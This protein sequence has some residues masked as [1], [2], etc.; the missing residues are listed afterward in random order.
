MDPYLKDLHLSV[1][2]GREN[3]NIGGW[4]VKEPSIFLGRRAHDE[5]WEGDGAMIPPPAEEGEPEWVSPK[6]RLGRDIRCLLE[7]TSTEAPT[8]IN[9]RVTA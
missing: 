7:L 2:G 5:V 1:G 4:K 8:R 6:A 3:R 9:F